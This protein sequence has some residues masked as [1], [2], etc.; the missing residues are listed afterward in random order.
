MPARRDFIIDSLFAWHT[1]PR[2]APGNGLRLPARGSAVQPLSASRR[3]ILSETAPI[4]GIHDVLVTAPKGLTPLLEAELRAIGLRGASAGRGGVRF[5]GTL[6][7]AYRACLWSRLASRVLLPLARAP[8]STYDA[9]HAALA[10]YPWET[11]LA[12][13]GALWIGFTARDAAL[14]HTHFGA[15]R[16]KDAIVDRFR[17]RFGVRPD[18]RR[19]D[20]D[21]RIHVHAQGAEAT[22]SIDLSGDSLHRRGYRG[23]GGTAPL[24]ENLAAALLVLA[25][26][27]EATRHGR[28]LLDPMCGS[29][30]LLVEAALMAADIAPGLLRE[31]FGFTRWLGHDAPAWQRLRDEAHARRAAARE[32]PWQEIGRAHV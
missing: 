31:T 23:D 11:H 12:P 2:P 28:P 8:A 16:V 20:P 30:T 4:D 15:Q 7:D 21:V 27:P 19:A 17:A 18:V 14:G 32:R 24:K 10:E 5:R 22:V 26:W 1:R 13:D 9:L 25:G 6:E 29:G 3:A